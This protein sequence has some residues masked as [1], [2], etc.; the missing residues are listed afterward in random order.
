MPVRI[1]GLKPLIEAITLDAYKSAKIAARSSRDTL[2]I[3]F[4]KGIERYISRETKNFTKIKTLVLPEK[5][6]NLKDIYVGPIVNFHE[7]LLSYDEILY[8]FIRE[9]RVVVTGIAGQGKSLLL[10][11]LFL[12]ACT[13]DIGFVPVFIELRQYAGEDFSVEAAILDRLNGLTKQHSEEFLQALLQNGSFLVMLDGYDEVPPAVRD[14]VQ[15]QIMRFSDTFDRCAVVITSRP[16]QE[17]NS[18]HSFL[19]SQICDYTPEQA[20]DVINK[21]PIDEQVKKEFLSKIN[22]D[23]LEKYGKLLKNPLLI[24]MMFLTFW[25]NNHIPDKE[26]LIYEK[27]FETFYTA[28]DNTKFLYKRRFHCLVAE[29]DFKRIWQTFCF[30]SYMRNQ[31][32][33]DINKFLE[34]GEKA[35]KMDNINVDLR[36]FFKDLSESICML[37]QDGESYT[38]MHR[39]YQEYFAARQFV[40]NSNN[41]YFEAFAVA[42]YRFSDDMQN[43]TR[44]INRNGFREKYVLPAAR[45]IV[46]RHKELE[47]DGRQE[48]WL[49]DIYEKIGISPGAFAGKSIPG[50]FAGKSIPGAF[51]GKSIPGAFAGKSIEDDGS[52]VDKGLAFWIGEDRERTPLFKYNAIL[53]KELNDNRRYPDLA[54]WLIRERPMPERGLHER[55]CIDRPRRKRFAQK[56]TTFCRVFE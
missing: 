35:T 40:E 5:Q 9:R 43:F 37:I 27:S 34:L 36:E 48:T 31:Y 28:H 32:R 3:F 2:H 56:Y 30:V 14:H 8:R 49:A 39:S 26:H 15:R 25:K 17:F 46:R 24:G 23:F 6:L 1:A 50:A 47:D 4:R 42:S 38:F 16:L 29:D 7:E 52:L 51:A 10:K 11:S 41:A 19:E 45:I 33:F 44:W 20:A 53:A 22:P 55:Y 21:I 18:W 12:D 54:R 13:I